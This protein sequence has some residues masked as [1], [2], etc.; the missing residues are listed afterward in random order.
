MVFHSL[1]S[2]DRGSYG[3]FVQISGRLFVGNLSEFP[4]KGDRITKR[5][6]EKNGWGIGWGNKFVRGVGRNPVV[7]LAG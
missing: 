3:F 1:G 5:R 2:F 7:I 6:Q 4:H